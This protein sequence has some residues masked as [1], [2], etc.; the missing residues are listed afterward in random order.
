M[1]NSI[2]QAGNIRIILLSVI[3]S[4]LL[5][6]IALI[7]TSFYIVRPGFAAVHLRLG[8][9]LKTE[10]SPGYYLKLPLVDSVT[11]FDLRIKKTTIETTALSK[12]LQG[13]SIG[14]VVNYRIENAEKL[15]QNVG[16]GFESIIIDPF[17]QEDVK[18]IVANYDA[19]NLIQKRQEAKEMVINQLRSRLATKDI[20][21]VDFKR[22]V[23][24]K[25]IA[26]QSA[27]MAENM[28]KQV[29]QETLQA[30]ARSDAEAYGLQIKRQAVTKELIELK[31]V[32][33]QM[34]AIE[35]WN[36]QMPRVV[37]SGNSLLPLIE[38]TN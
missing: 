1:N 25:Q 36:G 6:I 13:V 32:E 24:A 31:K 2:K 14:M 29:M 30:R 20:Q 21:L 22:A 28:T 5:V 27:K 11:Y 10:K 37:G 17:A 3:T 33:A 35:K 4:I 38:P 18:A 8:A 9:I 12:D 34:L 23:E 19:E 26:E 7:P 15:F 16:I